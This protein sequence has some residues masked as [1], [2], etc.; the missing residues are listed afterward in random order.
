[1]YTVLYC[2]CKAQFVSYTL[3]MN[4]FSYMDH[5]YQDAKM[6]FKKTVFFKM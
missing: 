6:R 4:I 5:G 2:F 3:T 1:M